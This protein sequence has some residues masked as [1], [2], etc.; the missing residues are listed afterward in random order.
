MCPR[1]ISDTGERAAG[2]GGR[3][4]TSVSPL[5]GLFWGRWARSEQAGG[6]LR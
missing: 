4:G 1:E 2:G 6:Q 5:G 3:G